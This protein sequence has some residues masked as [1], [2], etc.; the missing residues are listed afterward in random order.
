MYISFI[1]NLKLCGTYLYHDGQFSLI[2]ENKGI[3]NNGIIYM[4]TKEN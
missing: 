4:M 1:F 2:E 3:M